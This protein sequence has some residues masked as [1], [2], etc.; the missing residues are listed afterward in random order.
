MKHPMMA[1]VLG[2]VLAL[3]A[4]E[5]MAQQSDAHREHFVKCAK[6]CADCQVSCD[7]CF[8]HC[9]V[10]VEKGNKDHVKAMHACVDCADYCAARQ[11]CPL[12]RARCR[13]RLVR[14]VPGPATNAPGN[15]SSSRMTNTWRN[16][17]GP[18]GTAPSPAGP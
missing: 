8:H 18:A 12:V 6:V 11:K 4:T 14:D 16:A 2:A 5:A 10:L 17:P 7:S 15:A 13:R 3:C 9:A 1:V